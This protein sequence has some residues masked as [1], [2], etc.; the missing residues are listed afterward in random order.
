M[1][2]PRVKGQTYEYSNHMPLAIMWGK[3]IRK[4]GRMIF[5]FISFIDFAPTLLEIAGISPEVGKMQVMQG[6]S[7]SYHFGTGKDG[8]V[9]K[10]RDH[11]LL[12]QE[13]HVVGRPDDEGYPVRGIVK[14]G[15]FYLRNFKP[16]RWPAGNPETGY[17]NCDGSPTKSII[18]TLHRTGISKNF[19]DLS[20]GFRSSDELYDIGKD[21]ACVDNLANN[22]GYR[23]LMQN[24]MNLMFDELRAQEDPRV[25]GNGD[26]FDKYPYADNSTKDFY[27]R[28]MNKMISRKTAGWVDSTDFEET[29]NRK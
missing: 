15:F 16:G 4:P 26:I 27:N 9:D 24:L 6:R 14:E 17:L 19:W 12:G 21:P 11:I 22:A 7:F 20:F 23:S 10:S 28:Y 2:F 5:D 18:L 25:S 8:F 1:P 13:R 3:G 29:V